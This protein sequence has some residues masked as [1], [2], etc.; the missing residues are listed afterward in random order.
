MDELTERL[1]KM[2]DEIA[3]ITKRSKWM[4]KSRKKK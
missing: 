2:E 3:K 1:H 4:E